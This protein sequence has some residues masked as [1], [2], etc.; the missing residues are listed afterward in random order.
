MAPLRQQVIEQM[1]LRGFTAAGTADELGVA[2][3]SA[4]SAVSD[5]GPTLVVFQL[6]SGRACHPLFVRA[7]AATPAQ[8]VAAPAP[9]EGSATAGPAVPRGR[10]AE[11]RGRQPRWLSLSPLRVST[12][13][14]PGR[15]GASA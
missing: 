2:A 10:G 13:D 11:R 4:V 1:I 12:G 5:S 14:L 3:V 15:S 8:H 6:P 9:E 7:G